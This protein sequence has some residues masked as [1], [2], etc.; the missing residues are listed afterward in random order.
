MGGMGVPIILI[1]LLIIIVII[2][3]SRGSRIVYFTMGML[4]DFSKV[5]HPHI[6]T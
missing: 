5:C 4:Q 3:I 6:R 2:L 1:T